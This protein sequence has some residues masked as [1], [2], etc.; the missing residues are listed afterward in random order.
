[1][2]E[3]IDRCDLAEK[4][5][6]EALASRPDDFLLLRQAAAFHLRMDQPDRAE[7]YLRGLLERRVGALEE[8]TFWARRQLALAMAGEAGSPRREQA[9]A[10]IDLNLRVRPNSL[11]DGRAR[12]FVL[13][14]RPDRR[15]EWLRQFEATLRDRPA[16]PDELLV[17]AG[18]Y[19][20]DGDGATAR[21]QMVSLLA[22][23][24]RNPQ[25]LAHKVRGLLRRGER[26]EAEIYL[27]RLEQVQPRAA[28]TRA[29]GG[30]LRQGKEAPGPR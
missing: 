5:Y 14:S 24:G 15:R 13:A 25:Y 9:L 8:D 22:L 12:A 20:A 11:A 10:L 6:H 3:T 27:A 17:A 26:G 30:L 16:A 18:L 19:E 2:Y 21:E 29:L 23:D 7:P 1:V 4:Q 28:R